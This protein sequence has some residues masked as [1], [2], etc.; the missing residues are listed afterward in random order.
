MIA[1]TAVGEADRA[2]GFWIDITNSREGPSY[3]SLEIVFRACEKKAFG[4]KE[5]KSIWGTMRRMEI[6]IT[7]EVFNAYLGAPGGQACIDDGLQLLEGMKED[8]GYGPD[9]NT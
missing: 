7:R 1:W 5:A 6:D 3:N 2:L 4:E 8:V 9:M